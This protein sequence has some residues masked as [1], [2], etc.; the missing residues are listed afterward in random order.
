MHLQQTVLL[1]QGTPLFLLP[2]SAIPV[3]VPQQRLSLTLASGTFS[4][5]LG[6]PASCLRP[7]P[8]R[9]F[10]N[11]GKNKTK[12]DVAETNYVRLS[13]PICFV[14]EWILA[15]IRH[16]W[17]N[18]TGIKRGWQDQCIVKSEGDCYRAGRSPA[19]GGGEAGSSL[20]KE[21]QHIIYRYM[22]VSQ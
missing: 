1:S 14:R 12:H 16:F 22:K 9:F 2:I 13:N 5:F 7:S 18:N 15:T 19:R 3:G 11:L 8:T 6:Y 4:L 21:E 17:F 10:F 20:G